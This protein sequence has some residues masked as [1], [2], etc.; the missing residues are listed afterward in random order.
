MNSML[1]R[2]HSFTYGGNDENGGDEN[3]IATVVAAKARSAPPSTSKKKTRKR[4]QSSCVEPATTTTTTESLLQQPPLPPTLPQLP[5]TLRLLPLPPKKEKRKKKYFM[6]KHHSNHCKAE[7]TEAVLDMAL[8]IYHKTIPLRPHTIEHIFGDLLDYYAAAH[9]A[10]HSGGGGGRG[11]EEDIGDDDDLELYDDRRVYT[12]HLI[13]ARNSFRNRIFKQRRAERLQRAAYLR[14]QH[15]AAAAAAAATSMSGVEESEI[16]PSKN[17]SMTGTLKR[18]FK[19]KVSCVFGGV[20]NKS[21]PVQ[22]TTLRMKGKAAPTTPPAIIAPHTTAVASPAASASAAATASAAAEDATLDL[23]DVEAVLRTLEAATATPAADSTSVASSITTSSSNSSGAS[24]LVSDD[25]CCEDATATTSTVTATT[26]TTEFG[27]TMSSVIS[28]QPCNRYRR[29]KEVIAVCPKRK[30][31]VTFTYVVDMIAPC[32]LVTVSAFDI[33]IIESMPTFRPMYECLVAGGSTNPE[34]FTRLIRAAADSNLD[35]SQLKYELSLCESYSSR[36][37]TMLNMFVSAA[38]RMAAFAK[39]SKHFAARR[40]IATTTLQI[41]ADS[42]NEEEESDLEEEEEEDDAC[43]HHNWEYTMSIASTPKVQSPS[44]C[45]FAVP[46]PPP[47]TKHVLLKRGSSGGSSGGSGATVA[48]AETYEIT[49]PVDDVCVALSVYGPLG[50]SAIKTALLDYCVFSRHANNPFYDHKLPAAMLGPW[51]DPV[52]YACMRVLEPI[53]NVRVTDEHIRTWMRNSDVNVFDAIRLYT[54]RPSMFPQAWNY[55][56]PMLCAFGYPARPFRSHQWTLIDFL[57]LAALGI[58]SIN[59]AASASDS[60]AAAEDTNVITDVLFPGCSREVFNRTRQQKEEVIPRVFPEVLKWI[61]WVQQPLE[62]N[63]KIG[64]AEDILKSS[65][66]MALA[67]EFNERLQNI[68]EIGNMHTAAASLRRRVSSPS[69]VRNVRGNA[70]TATTATTATAAATATAGR[71]KMFSI[72]EYCLPP[73]DIIEEEEEGEEED[74]EEDDA[75]D[76]LYS[77]C[78]FSKAYVFDVRGSKWRMPQNMTTQVQDKYVAERA[79]EAMTMVKNAVKNCIKRKANK[80]LLI[81]PSTLHVEYSSSEIA[82]YLEDA[83][84]LSEELAPPDECVLANM[85]VT[86]QYQAAAAAAATGGGGG[87]GKGKGGDG[88]GSTASYFFMHH[89]PTAFTIV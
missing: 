16:V 25:V 38:L 13:K 43:Q 11:D 89:H 70:A 51:I 12:P 8:A 33:P 31:H 77:F 34:D 84:A 15:K 68:I 1:R 58:E 19:K 71:K 83:D 66:L 44:C 40:G 81:R 75:V 52:A 23:S 9:S 30:V 45:T 76:T 85:Y 6:K 35:I 64:S 79:Y 88:D 5:S 3:G 62:A 80:Y 14:E 74:E 87:G 17:N 59:P 55:V 22:L 10:A 67:T 36:P 37:M 63:V 7:M 82:H 21:K 73:E 53:S 60:A 39:P 32:A 69:V 65:E 50:Y 26:T 54:F 29:I 47:K 78:L 27:G 56:G 20:D 46:P 61:E 48:T 28:N 57:K 42:L 41:M 18:A 86:P 2:I 49:F 72:S 24:G 4:C